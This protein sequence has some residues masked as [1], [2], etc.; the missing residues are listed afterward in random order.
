MVTMLN[1]FEVVVVEAAAI[2]TVPTC[3]MLQPNDVIVFDG[4]CANSVT[5]MVHS[6]D[7]QHI[8]VWQHAVA[9]LPLCYPRGWFDGL[10]E[11][12]DV[13]HFPA[14]RRAEAAWNRA[15]GPWLKKGGR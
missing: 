5:C 1:E 6:V 11:T 2:E 4:G 10:L 7:D 14:G 3:A 8:Y 15:L 9:S 13:A 12:A